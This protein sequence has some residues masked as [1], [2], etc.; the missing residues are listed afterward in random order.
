[1]S[2]S[3]DPTSMFNW[4]PVVEGLGIPSPRTLLVPFDREA[5]G[6]MFY[7]ED[8]PGAGTEMAKL[9]AA[10][11]DFGFP[12][13]LRTDLASGKHSWSRTCYVPD[14][15]SLVAHAYEVAEFN[16]IAGLFGLPWTGF[17]LRELLHL[18]STFTA[19]DGMPVARERRYFAEDGSVLCHH[20]YWPE[21]A[22][23]EGWSRPRLPD[24][25]RE[26]LALLNDESDDPSSL[27]EWAG[28]V[29]KT[30]GGAWSVDFARSR[31]GRW[32]LIDMAV[33]GQSWHPEHGGYGGEAA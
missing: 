14:A 22:I 12:L 24:D 8:A 17:A 32:W 7:G 9:C 10:A 1:M 29:T 4:L 18:E 19:F 33:A 13:F 3:R 16:E 23:E 27:G 26:R 20:P 21:E 5:V 28:A 30:L 25:W 6:P 15:E 11:V 2:E 31:D